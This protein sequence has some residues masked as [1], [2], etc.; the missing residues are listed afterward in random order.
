[1]QVTLAIIKPDAVKLTSSHGL[2]T[3]DSGGNKTPGG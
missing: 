3:V 1:M 2:K